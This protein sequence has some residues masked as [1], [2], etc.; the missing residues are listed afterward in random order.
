M[1]LVT[2]LGG[3]MRLNPTPMEDKL[4]VAY[5]KCAKKFSKAKCKKSVAK[6]V[7]IG[8]HLAPKRTLKKLTRSVGVKYSS[9]RKRTC[10]RLSKK[11]T[12][13]LK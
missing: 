5:T 12:R 2:V 1:A 6:G 11:L 3:G 10:K 13:R 7:S 4:Q 9:N 8:C